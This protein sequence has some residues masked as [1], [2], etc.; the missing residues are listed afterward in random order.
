MEYQYLHKIPLEV[1]LTTMNMFQLCFSLL[2]ADIA[3]NFTQN[4]KPLLNLW[5]TTVLKISNSLTL[6]LLK[7]LS[8]PL[9]SVS[10]DI[11]LLNFSSTVKLSIMLD[12]ENQLVF[13][14]GLEKRP[15]HLPLKLLIKNHQIKLKKITMQLLSFSVTK[16]PKNSVSGLWLLKISTIL[17]S[18]TSLTVHY[19]LPLELK[20]TPLFY[21][22]NLMKVEMISLVNSLLKL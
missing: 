4:S 19:G 17:S 12:Q 1:L 10:K 22:N 21:S 5:I 6:M 20:K 16:I 9:N 11:Q 2:G 14:T 7:N 18:S 3:K 8:Q 13:L 15:N